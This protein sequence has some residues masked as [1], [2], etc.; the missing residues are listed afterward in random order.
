MTVRSTLT[1]FSDKMTYCNGQR[2]VCNRSKNLAKYLARPQ[3]NL[4]PLTVIESTLGVMSFS[5]YLLRFIANLGLLTMLTLDSEE[6]KTKRQELYYS[7]LNDSIWCT[8]NLIQF[9]WLTSKTSSAAGLYGMQL[10]T[11]V[12]LLD[13]LIL[14]I[15]HQQD[16][17]EYDMKYQQ[18]STDIERSQLTMAWE[19]KELHHVRSLLSNLAFVALFGI[20]SFSSL[21]IPFSPLLS[22]VSLINSLS[23]ML[24]DLKLKRQLLDQMELNQASQAQIC[25]QKNAIITACLHELNQIILNSVFYPFGFFLLIT[26]PIG[27]TLMAGVGM[28][29]VHLLI[30]HLIDIEPGI[31]LPRST[32]EITL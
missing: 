15:R 31:P 19:N 16:K 1:F 10:E 14:L 4:R 6:E 25:Q 13:I 9:F 32:A 24:I 18:A 23:K 12:Q 28:I 7:L 21:S 27:L 11:V 3:Y 2:I 5:L 8:V 17:K 29:A 22:A 30:K 20:I 26:A